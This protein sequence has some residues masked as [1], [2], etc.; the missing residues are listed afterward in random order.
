MTML[1]EEEKNNAAAYIKLQDD[2]R[3]LIIDTVYTELNNYGGLLQSH[4]KTNVIYAPEFEQKVK[5]VIKNQMMK[6]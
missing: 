6:Y 3:Q 1:T 2:V 5:D 4:I